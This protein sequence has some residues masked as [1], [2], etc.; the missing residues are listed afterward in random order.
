M[1]SIVYFK[2]DCMI[3]NIMS[4]LLLNIVLNITMFNLTSN[5]METVVH[6]TYLSNVYHVYVYF[7]S[8]IQHA[9]FGETLNFSI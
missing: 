2:Y 4:F 9:F 8:S 3:C 7:S 6:K 5:L 1:S